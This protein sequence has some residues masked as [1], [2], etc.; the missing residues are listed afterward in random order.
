MAEGISHVAH[1]AIDT[2]PPSV[3]IHSLGSSEPTPSAALVRR[4]PQ[5]RHRHSAINCGTRRHGGGAE[6]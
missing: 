1:G 4:A 2:T 3:R 5:K 6:G